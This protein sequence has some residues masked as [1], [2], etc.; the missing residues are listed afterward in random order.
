MGVRV[1]PAVAV[2]F[3]PQSAL[4]CVGSVLGEIN[5]PPKEAESEEEAKQAA[6]LDCD[7]FEAIESVGGTA[8]SVRDSPSAAPDRTRCSMEGAHRGGFPRNEVT[9]PIR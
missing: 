2:Q 9:S 3:P 5:G 1:L 7:R 6:A 4:K 8:Q